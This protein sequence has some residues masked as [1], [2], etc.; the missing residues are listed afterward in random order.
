MRASQEFLH[1]A[2]AGPRATTAT[3]RGDHVDAEA[4][5]CAAG[6]VSAAV[7]RRK[8]LDVLVKLSAIELVL[9][10]VVG[11]MNLVVEVRQIVFARPVTD[12][13][14][15]ATRSAVA[16]GATAVGLLQELLVLASG[17]VRG[18]RVGSQGQG[19]R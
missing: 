11:E 12:L 14:L 3:A 9:D 10:S 4:G 15:V 16:V 13:V 8:E 17:L 1:P 7:V 6:G 2:R 5:L 18:Q 19:A